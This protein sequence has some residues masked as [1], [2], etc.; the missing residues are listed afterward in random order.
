MSS[1]PKKPFLGQFIGNVPLRAILIV[2]FILQIV[3]AV[4]TVGYLSFRSGQKSVNDMAV[5]LQEE[6]SDRAKQQV[7]SY[8]ERPTSNLKTI[9]AAIKTEQIDLNDQIKQQRFLWH[10][11]NQEI[12]IAVNLATPEGDSILVERFSGHI[13]TRLINSTTA[14]YRPAYRLDDRGDRAE[15]I[16]TQKNFDPRTRP[17]YK[18]AIAAKKP[19]WTPFFINFNNL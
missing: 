3:A 14:P 9:A 6:V 12:A 17:W 18:N 4:G 2:P 10:L 11:V 13:Q 1:S 5:K 8:L 15:L 16:E 7:L 19:V